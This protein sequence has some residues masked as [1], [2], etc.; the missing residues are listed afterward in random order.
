M[1]TAMLDLAIRRKQK[2]SVLC[3]AICLGTPGILAAEAG[4]FT[5]VEGEVDLQRQGQTESIAVQ[6]DTMVGEMEAVQTGASSWAQ[7]KFLDGSTLMMAPSSKI[8]MESYPGQTQ[9]K[10]IFRLF[11]GLVRLIVNPQARSENKE[12][13]IRTKTAALRVRSSECYLLIGPDFTDVLVKAG[14]VAVIS[15]SEELP[16][17]DADPGASPELSNLL[18]QAGIRGA[19]ANR[20]LI[21]SME[22]ARLAA[23]RRTS[24]IPL[25]LEHFQTLEGLMR[26]GLPANLG[27]TADPGKL[28][29]NISR[30]GLESP[31]SPPPPPLLPPEIGPS[32]PGGGAI[33]SPSA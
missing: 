29:E 28:L 13:L 32:F 9:G 14:K 11:Q 10:A 8:F 3:L 6:P 33:A 16:L 22:G 4:R 15:P 27:D 24:I 17:P 7:I 5:Q 21:N 23:G 19:A 2:L 26:L 20:V 1:K 25:N 12:F 31:V 30:I 18:K